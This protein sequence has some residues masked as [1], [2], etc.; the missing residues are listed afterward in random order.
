MTLS[1][2]TSKISKNFFLKIL[3]TDWN[4]IFGGI[5]L[6]LLTIYLQ[7]WY[8]PWDVSGGIKYWGDLVLYKKN[9]QPLTFSLLNIGIILGAFISANLSKKFAIRIVPKTEI[10]KGILGGILMGLGASLAGGGNV[11]GFYISMANFSGSAILMMIGLFIGI[12]IGIIYQA[13]ALEKKKILGGKEIRFPKLNP[14]LAIIFLI[15]LIITKNFILILGAIIGYVLQKSRFCMLNAFRDPFFS[16]RPHMTLALIF[17]LAIAA[18]GIGLL[19]MENM[20][21]PMIFI[22]SVFGWGGIIGGFI[23]GLGMVLAGGG[24]VES[25]WR[26]GEGQIKFILVLF[27]FSITYSLVKNLLENFKIIS[28][29]KVYLPEYLGYGGSFGLIF[30]ILLIWSL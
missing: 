16:G 1:S 2:E 15:F 18:L 4:P 26:L 22:K 21:N 24:S 29:V 13:R 19:K 27:C 7:F 28:G 11:S 17:S 6:S 3:E 20:Q 23:F 25:L 14:I 10:L 12:Y 30:G 8:F 5:L 9:I